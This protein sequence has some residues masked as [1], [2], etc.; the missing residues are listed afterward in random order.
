MKT[1]FTYSVLRY[2]H[3][4]FTGEFVNVGV[5][6]VAPARRF[7]GVKCNS[8]IARISALFPQV[9]APHFKRQIRFVEG[10]AKDLAE[11]ISTELALE[12]KLGSD[13]ANRILPQDASSFQWSPEGGGI[14][15]SP[16]TTL[17]ELFERMV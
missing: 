12:G 3:D 14:T 6:V 5:L 11:Q 9:N 16:E 4:V 10:K 1:P 13:F 17:N 7:I 2:A 8:R 15:E